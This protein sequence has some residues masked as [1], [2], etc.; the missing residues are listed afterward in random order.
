[1]SAQSVTSLVAN[2]VVTGRGCQDHPG[3]DFSCRQTSKLT[4]VFSE[5]PTCRGAHQQ[6]RAAVRTTAYCLVPGAAPG[7]GISSG[8]ELRRRGH[9]VVAVDLPADDP[10]AGLAEYAD[11]VVEAIGEAPQTILVAQ[12][13]AGFTAPL[14]C[15][16]R[17]VALLVL[18]NAMIP[19]AGET[20]GEWWSNT[21]QES[22]K[23]ANDVAQGRPADAG[24]DLLTDFFHDVPREIVEE[25]AAH[26]RPQSEGPFAD[27]WPL[28]AWPPLPTRVVIGRDDRFFPAD[29]QRRIAEE[30]LGILADEVPGGHLVALS[31]PLPLVERLETYR[32]EILGRSSALEAR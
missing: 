4:W 2:V 30:R 1:M 17:E 23:R 20:A 29:F 19:I 13:L 3:D 5:P 12:S 10:Q 16:R 24:F 14:V 15:E 11:V 8:A 18:V 32:L 22:A 9:H 28:A 26:D 6:D 25:A 7:T 21:A 31:H 27:R